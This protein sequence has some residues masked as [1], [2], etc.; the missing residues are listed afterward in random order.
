VK[1]RSGEEEWRMSD[2]GFSEAVTAK[3][4]SKM[5]SFSRSERNLSEC[6]SPGPSISRSGSVVSLASSCR[7][8][9]RYQTPHS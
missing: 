3:P 5:A 4:I 2:S 8:P 6:E 9:P 1:R 7:L